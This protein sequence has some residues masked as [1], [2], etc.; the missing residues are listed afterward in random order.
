MT[1]EAWSGIYWAGMNIQNLK[2]S[3]TDIAKRNE[4]RKIRNVDSN[5]ESYITKVLNL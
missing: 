2:E 4:L 3:V 1:G 5:I